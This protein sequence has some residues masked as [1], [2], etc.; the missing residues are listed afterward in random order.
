MMGED[1][2]K[3]A[4]EYFKEKTAVRGFGVTKFNPEKSKHLETATIEI[5]GNW[6]DVVNLRGE[7]Y[8]EGSRI[9]KIVINYV[10]DNL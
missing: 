6:I 5:M 1:F 7:I 10:L 2:I 4:H 9:P 8:E 3:L